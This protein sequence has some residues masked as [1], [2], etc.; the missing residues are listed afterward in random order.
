M[1]YMMGSTVVIART[2]M[3]LSSQPNALAKFSRG[4][5]SLGSPRCDVHSA[6]TEFTGTDRLK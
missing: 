2:I 5:T 1:L 4:W 6:G 3:V